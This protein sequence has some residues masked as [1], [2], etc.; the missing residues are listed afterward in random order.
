V[1]ALHLDWSFLTAQA[2]GGVRTSYFRDS[3]MAASGL[4][5]L[6]GS[7]GGTVMRVF[8][9]APEVA[10]DRVMRETSAHYLLGVEGSADDKPGETHAIRVT[11]RRRGAQVRSRTQFI[12][13]EK[14]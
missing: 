13:P 8:G 14:R 6:A 9:T 5:R 1:F 3:N 4:E 11:V 10:F 7:A 2:R 12:V